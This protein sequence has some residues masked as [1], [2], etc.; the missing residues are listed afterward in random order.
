MPFELES[1]IFYTTCLLTPAWT[2]TRRLFS[3]NH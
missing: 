1:C 2:H 3:V